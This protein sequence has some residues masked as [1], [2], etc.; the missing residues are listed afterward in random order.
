ME[1]QGYPDYLIYDDGRVFSKK[2]NRFIKQHKNYK[3]YLRVHLCNDESIKFFRVHRLVGLHYIPNPENKPMIDHI[4]REK[5]D[6][7]KEN[8]RWATGTENQQNTGFQKNNKLGI[9]NICYQEPNNRYQY[10]KFING[11]RHQ[12]YFKT[13]QEAIDY[14][15]QFEDLISAPVVP[16]A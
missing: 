16:T 6:N 14:K 4:N 2:R 3:G 10:K 15:N 7:R 11:V 12:K 5:D 9:K 13:L 8:L 1:I